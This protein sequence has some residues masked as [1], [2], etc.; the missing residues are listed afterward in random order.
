MPIE[1]PCSSKVSLR[2]SMLRDLETH[3]CPYVVPIKCSSLH[4]H[5]LIL[6]AI[7]QYPGSARSSLW[8]QQEACVVR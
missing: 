5:F 7:L 1:V 2:S 3:S 4:G 8:Q 6:A